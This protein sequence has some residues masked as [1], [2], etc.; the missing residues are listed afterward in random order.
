L[1]DRLY[2]LLDFALTFL[3]QLGVGLLFI[4]DL[5]FKTDDFVFSYRLAG[6]LVHNQ[7]VL[8]HRTYNEIGYAFPGGH[9]AYP[10]TNEQ[11]LMREFK[12]EISA[13]VRIK[14]L[15]WVGE[16]FFPFQGKP[17][18]QIC[19]FYLVELEDESQILWKAVFWEMNL[20]VIKLLYLNFPGSPSISLTPLFFIHL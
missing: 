2:F 6:I 12:E 16:I 11:T 4:A 20:L 17:C 18:H 13:N 15:K 8:L 1:P 7:K 3:L 19:L 10:E 9:A 5:F 14:D